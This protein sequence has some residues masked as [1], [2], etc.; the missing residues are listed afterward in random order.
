MFSFSFLSFLFTLVNL[1]SLLV[2]ALN[3]ST[4]MAEYAL[5]IGAEVT[6]WTLPDRIPSI[7]EWGKTTCLLPR[8]RGRSYERLLKSWEQHEIQYLKWVHDN[9]HRC[10]ENIRDLNGY[11]WRSGVVFQRV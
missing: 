1:S 8:F 11:L 3:H 6:L 5:V 10:N 2:L 7:A 9:G 4:A